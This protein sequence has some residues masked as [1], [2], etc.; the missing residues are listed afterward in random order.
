MLMIYFF[1]VISGACCLLLFS[2]FSKA[3]DPLCRG[4]VD[5]A[6]PLVAKEKSTQNM[7]EEHFQML[8]RKNCFKKIV[9][10]FI[11]RIYGHVST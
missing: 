5:V 7:S 11:L 10:N 1:G 3:M 4:R 8:K 6:E 9:F 2:A